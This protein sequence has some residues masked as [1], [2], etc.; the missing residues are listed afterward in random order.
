MD[1]II[2]NYIYII[3]LLILPLSVFAS[4]GWS[5][6]SHIEELTPTSHGRFLVKLKDAKNP[7][8][9]KQEDMYYLN[10]DFSGSEQMFRTL[11]EA[12]SSDKMVRVYATGRCELN[13][14]SEISS[15][16]ITP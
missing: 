10:Y 6:Y 12:V 15:V 1:T 3:T 8:G 4:A 14:Y 7:S 11:L 16:T 2:K 13:G 9:C 5:E